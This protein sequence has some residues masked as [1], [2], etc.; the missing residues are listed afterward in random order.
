[1]MSRF[2]GRCPFC[3]GETTVK[4]VT[5]LR[6]GASVEGSFTGCPFCR[7]SEENLKLIL[8]FIKNRGNMR[9]TQ[10]DLGV[11]YPVLKRMLEEAIAEMEEVDSAHQPPVEKGEIIRKLEKGEITPEQAIELLQSEG[12][13][14]R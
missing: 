10:Q 6:C 11:S 3:G 8:T 12:D 2:P 5:C 14:G 1:M 4:R 7:L 9:K 13:H